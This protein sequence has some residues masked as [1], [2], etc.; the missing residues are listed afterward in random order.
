MRAWLTKKRQSRMQTQMDL[1]KQAGISRAYLAQI[2]L[3]MR[4][5]S[6]RV[7]KKLANVLSIDWTRF[8]EDQEPD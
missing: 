6:I 1:A 7:A 3:G 5:P 2:E 8:Y 4:N